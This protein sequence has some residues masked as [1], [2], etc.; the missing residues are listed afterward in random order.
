MITLKLIKIANILSKEG[1]V[2]DK[3]SYQIVKYF[4]DKTMLGIYLQS[5]DT[6]T[7]KRHM[8]SPKGMEINK[9]KFNN[10]ILKSIKFTLNELR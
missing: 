6:L 5:S 1:D 7:N 2:V 8:M 4:K 10:N 3:E 9:N